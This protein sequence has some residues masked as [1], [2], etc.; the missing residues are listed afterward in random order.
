[1]DSGTI[2]IGLIMLALCALPFILSGRNRKSKE[3]KIKKSFLDLA[4]KNN[5]SDL[6][7]D[8]WYGSAIG[9][10]VTNHQLVFYRKIKDIETTHILNL[11]DIQKSKVLKVN[12]LNNHIEKLELI[13]TPYGKN[14]NE[15]NL[16]FYN[17][18]IN[19]QLNGEFQLIDK[20]NKLIN[21]TIYSIG[22]FK[23]AV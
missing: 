9:I 20:W 14:N 5:I 12:D 23:K 15:I 21:E 13:L 6:Q 22:N 19:P 16:E 7:K 4:Q 18:E 8:I 1:M 11:K 3:E 17:A 2:I 10:N